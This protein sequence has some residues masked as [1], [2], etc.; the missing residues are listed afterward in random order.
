MQGAIRIISSIITLLQ[1][2]RLAVK[3]CEIRDIFPERGTQ[4]N[5][6]DTQIEDS[7]SPPSC[8]RREGCSFRIFLIGA[9]KPMGRNRIS[10]QTIP[11]FPGI[12]FARRH[13]DGIIMS[14]FPAKT[15]G[16]GKFVLVIRQEHSVQCMKL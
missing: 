2:V 3:K 10:S 11:L 12:R 14:F 7:P 1:D 5:A 13:V 16:F 4:K 15:G 8:G 9:E 6:F